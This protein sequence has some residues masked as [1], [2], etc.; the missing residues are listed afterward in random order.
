MANCW[1]GTGLNRS[2][3]SYP[4]GFP[5]TFKANPPGY[6][7]PAGFSHLLPVVS[8]VI[9]FGLINP[10]TLSFSSGPY[11]TLHADYWQTWNDQ[12]K[13]ASLVTTCLNNGTGC[14]PQ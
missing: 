7:C 5:A 1:D 14:G 6:P 10:A 3:L 2:D 11:Y 4:V 9:H 13:L 8:E 12:A